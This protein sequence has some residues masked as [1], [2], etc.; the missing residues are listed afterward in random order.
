MQKLLLKKLASLKANKHQSVIS[1][2]FTL[3]ELIVVVVIIGILSAIAVPAFNNAG[4]KAKQKEAST[5][6]ASY[7]KAA[8][9]F[10]AENSNAPRNARDLGQFVS[11]TGCRQ[12]NGTYCKTNNSAIIDLTNSTATTWYTPSGLYR[13]DWRNSGNY[14]QFRALP[15][16]G[17]AN[18]GYGVS[19]C[20]NRVTGATKGLRSNSKGS[21]IR[22]ICKLLIFFNPTDLLDE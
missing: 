10:Y 22:D 12:G 14:S 21:K 19:A 2:G 7:V 18:N 6:L 11:V 5:Q 4:D 1:K 8:Q 20:F 15:W 9:A 17:Y 3:V 16:G 13:I